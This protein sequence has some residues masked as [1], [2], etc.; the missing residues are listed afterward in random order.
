MPCRP[1][2]RRAAA[3]RQCGLRT[4]QAASPPLNTGALAIRH[5]AALYDVERGAEL[6]RAARGAPALAGPWPTLVEARRHSG[7]PNGVTLA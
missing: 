2:H 5:Y 7:A 3:R 6:R 1:Y 4:P